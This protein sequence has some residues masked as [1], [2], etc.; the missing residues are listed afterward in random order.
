[1]EGVSEL[2]RIASKRVMRN[3]LLVF[4]VKIERGNTS[5]SAAGSNGFESVVPRWRHRDVRVRKFAGKAL[6]VEELDAGS[7]RSRCA[8]RDNVNR[9]HR[10]SK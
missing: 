9:A 1:M 10:S 4:T 6:S 8:S 5:D 7:P 3:E 2:R